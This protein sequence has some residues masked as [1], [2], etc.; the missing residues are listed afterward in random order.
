MDKGSNRGNKYQDDK[1]KGV[2]KEVLSF[3]SHAFT[4]AQLET[5]EMHNHFLENCSEEA[6]RE[7][8]QVESQ[9]RRYGKKSGVG[10]TTLYT[11]ALGR[12]NSL[13]H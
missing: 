11:L 9:T 1:G 4:R 8:D 2:A 6:Q 10:S 3:F 7:V 5:W 13:R 12:P